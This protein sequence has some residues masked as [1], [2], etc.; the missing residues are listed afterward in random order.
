MSEDSAASTD[1]TE[2]REGT[3][4]ATA[5]ADPQVAQAREPDAGEDQIR[6][7][8]VQTVRYGPIILVAAGIGAILGMI[9]AFLVPVAEDAEYTLAQIVGL[10]AVIGA[11][12]GLTLGAVLSLILGLVAKRRTGEAYAIQ[13][14]VR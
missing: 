12:V 5:P 8:L 6:V 2:S 11:I 9:A 14:D 7:S 3:D 4:H 10:M 13:S 1:G